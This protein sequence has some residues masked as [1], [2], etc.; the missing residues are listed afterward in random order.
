[1]NPEPCKTRGRFGDSLTS[2]P[3]TP[4]TNRF[5]RQMPTLDIDAPAALNRFLALAAIDGI[6]G[7]EREVMNR[8]I[9]MLRAGGVDERWIQ[10]DDA[11]SRTPSGGEVGNLIVSLPG[12][13]PG[14]TTLLSAHADTV[15]ICQGSTP[16]VDGD[17]VKSARDSTGLGADDRAGCA[18]I[19]TAVIELLRS[20]QPHAPVKLL[21]CI[22]EEIGLRGARYVDAKLLG[23]IERAFNFDGGHLEKLTVGATGGERMTIALHG[24]P[25]HAGVAPQAG[26]SAIVMAARAIDQLHRE[27]WLGLVDKPG[28]GVGTANVGVISGG[29]A[30]NVITPLV[31]LRAEARSHDSAMR[32]RIIEEI[33]KAFR[34]AADTITTDTGVSGRVEISTSVDYEAFRLAPDHPTV[35]A[36]ERAIRALGREPY[37]EVTNGGLDANWLN[38]HGIPAVTLGCGQCQIHTSD[39]TLSIPDYLDACRVAVNLLLPE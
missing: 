22:Q 4:T 26:A 33:G 37:C 29:D 27:G 7:K 3:L 10:F 21:F 24:V 35:Q 8:I 31:H 11:N 15:P 18:A 14:P 6:S 34:A 16:V 39:E 9:A 32:S 12:T 30:T 23:P 2:G 17:M 36:A 25:A 28:L 5:F 38:L 19:V 1:M 20:G 13:V